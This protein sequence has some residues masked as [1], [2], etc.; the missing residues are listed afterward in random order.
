MSVASLSFNRQHLSSAGSY[1]SFRGTPI[2]PE[3]LDPRLHSRRMTWEP[4]AHLVD[5]RSRLIRATGTLKFSTQNIEGTSWVA[6][7]RA[8][9]LNLHEARH[10]YWVTKAPGTG[11]ATVER[12]NLTPSQPVQ[13]RPYSPPGRPGWNEHFTVAHVRAPSVICTT[14]TA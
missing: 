3:E 12:W 7:D 5:G 6:Y 1:N 2:T 14:P 13:K 11:F 8:H 10:P 4:R 9:R